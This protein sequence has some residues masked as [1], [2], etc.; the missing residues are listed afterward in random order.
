MPQ[1]YFSSKNGEQEIVLDQDG[2]VQG[3]E[4]Q[5]AQSEAVVNDGKPRAT[6]TAEKIAFKAETKKLLD[7]VA[8][9]IY[10]DKEVFLRELLSNC[11]DALE[12]QRYLEISGSSDAGEHQDLQIQIETNE[13]ERVISIFDSGIGMTREE[14]AENLG[15]IAK[16]GSMEFKDDADKATEMNFDQQEAAESIIGQF[17]VGFYSSFIVSDYVEVF[18]KSGR[19]AQA[20]R[21]SSDGSGDYELAT[22][23]QVGFSRGTK[24]VLHLRNNCLQFSKEGDVEKIIKKYSIFNKYPITLNGQNLSNLQAIWYRDKR[25]VT[26]DEYEMFWEQHADTKIPYKYKLHYSTDV[27]L[28]IKALL[29]IPST[30][31]E[32]MQMMQETVKIDL[33]SRKVLIK[34]GCQELI[35]SYLRFVKGIVDCED[36]PLNISRETYQD[37]NLIAKLRNV[38]TRR[39]LKFIEDEMKRDTRTYDKWHADFHNFLKEGV[40]SDNENQEQLLRLMRYGSSL[41]SS[42]DETIS[43]EDYIKSMKEG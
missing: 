25:E 34:P 35:P 21:W 15:T 23:D 26:Q 6:G 7:I 27:P 37:S 3:Q 30:H 31:Q 13:K 24:I 20:V 12:K 18:S 10:T 11:S 19:D 22:V 43:L 33:Y 39:I 5:Q 9:S 32:K 41:H 17:G 29:Y 36:L 2:N 4:A 28:A 16:S 42:S 14:I 1:F 8:K 40:L 38:I